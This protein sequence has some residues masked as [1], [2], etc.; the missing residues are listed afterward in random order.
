MAKQESNQLVKDY[1]YEALMILMETRD[2]QDITITEITQKAGVSR[3]GYYRNYTTKEEIISTKFEEIFDL[4]LG[5]MEQME[6]VDW[7]RANELAYY[8]FDQ[9][10][11][12]LRNMLKA[13]LTEMLLQSF[14]AYL[15]N[16]NGRIYTGEKED[17]GLYYFASYQVGGFYNMMLD[18][19]KNDFKES[20]E[21]MAKI[22][23]LI[24]IHPEDYF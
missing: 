3:M 14:D 17:A 4:C 16:L 22:I 8:Y 21:L 9:N 10:K 7:A 23:N 20:P 2:F 12:L 24:T 6:D 1:I 13:N 19:V 18:W 15:T 5:D 11:S